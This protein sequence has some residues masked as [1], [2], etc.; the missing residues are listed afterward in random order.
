MIGV[1]TDRAVHQPCRV[2]GENKA[3]QHVQLEVC[4]LLF[5]LQHPLLSQRPDDRQRQP[6]SSMFTQDEDFSIQQ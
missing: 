6:A 4:E 3:S 5:R 1:A 2:P